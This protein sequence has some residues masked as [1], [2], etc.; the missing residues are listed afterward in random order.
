MSSWAD[1]SDDVPPA[2]EPAA[3][4]GP[5]RRQRLQVRDTAG[6]DV[7]FVESNACLPCLALLGW[8]NNGQT[9]L[10]LFFCVSLLTTTI[11]YILV[12][13]VRYTSIRFDTIRY[14]TIVETT[15][16]HGRFRGGSPFFEQQWKEQPL[17]GCQTA[18]R[19]VGV[20]GH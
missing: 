19:S 11:L 13:T 2:A 10:T 16:C 17:W 12:C 14:D 4:S 18:R 20:Q 3:P 7:T 5:P 8:V 15:Q 1:A 6:R 9:G